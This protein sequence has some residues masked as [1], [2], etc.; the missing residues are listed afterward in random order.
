MLPFQQL[1]QL[2]KRRLCHLSVWLRS[3]R[4][5]RE[6]RAFR[7]ILVQRHDRQIEQQLLFDQL[8]NAH[9]LI[10]YDHRLEPR[11]HR[12]RAR[13]IVDQGEARLPG[14][15]LPLRFEATL[16]DEPG[17]GDHRELGHRVPELAPEAHG[18]ARGSF[19][20]RELSDEA[21]EFAERYRELELGLP[22]GQRGDIPP[23]RPGLGHRPRMIGSRPRQVEMPPMPPLILASTSRYRRMLLERLQL[24]FGTEAPGVAEGASAGERPGDCAARLAA[25]KARAVAAR[26]P[27]AVVI[28]SD[29]VA[30]CGTSMLGKPG[31]AA[32]CREQLA[33]LSG[34]VAE[35]HTACV[36][37]A[38]GRA[39]AAHVDLTRVHFRRL[40]APE[41]ARYVEREQPF[42]CAGGFKSEGLG[43]ALFE[44]IEAED[45][46]ALIGLP[47]VWL[48]GALRAVG[49]LL[50]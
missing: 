20:T 8:A 18:A 21:R 45:P 44:R 2:C 6:A 37:L 28:G 42:D 7:R 19:G 50:P 31:D 48:A 46:T 11:R 32:R 36:V 12:I 17:L 27:G 35:F 10:L 38:P 9:A 5:C 26:H 3:P 49:Y 41:I 30:A 29:Q 33:S 40:E 24:A 25:A 15:R 13:C 43:I 22:V 1:A 34:R 39:A 14:E 47:L 16:A 4:S 23:L